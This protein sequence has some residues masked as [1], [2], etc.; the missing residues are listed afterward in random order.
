V[1]AQDLQVHTA[2]ACSATARKAAL[3]IDVWLDGTTVARFDVPHP[4]A[5]F[6]DLHTQLVPW[7]PRV[8]VK[9]HLAEVAGNVGAAD[10]YAMDADERFAGIGTRRLRDVDPLEFAGLFEL[11]GVHE[12]VISDQ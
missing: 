11:N 12:E 8:A 1:Y 2:I 5:N 6:D 7:D 3:A 10:S 9:G 4:L